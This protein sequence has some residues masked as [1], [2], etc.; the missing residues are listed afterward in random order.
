MTTKPLYLQ[1]GDMPTT[2]HAALSVAAPTV[3]VYTPDTPLNY[4]EILAAL[5]LAHGSSR[6][7]SDAVWIGPNAPIAAFTIKRWLRGAGIHTRGSASEIELGTRSMLFFRTPEAVDDLPITD[8]GM[9][10]VHNAHDVHRL[11]SGLSVERTLVVG[12]P[13]DRATHWFAKPAADTTIHRL[14]SVECAGFARNKDWLKKIL[15]AKQSLPADV[16]AR[17]HDAECAYA[18]VGEGVSFDL[19]GWSKK[20]LP[21]YFTLAPSAMHVA[22][23]ERSIEML[24][25]RGAREAWI[26]P[27]GAAK[28]TV[29]SLA[30]PLACICHGWER[31]VWLLSDTATQA[32]LNLRAVRDELENNE[33]LEADYP[34]ACGEGETWTDA[35]LITRNDVMIEALGA[36]KKLR[37][38]RFRQWRPSLIVCDDIENDDHSVSLT[39]REKTR[40]WFERAVLKAGT[41][42]TNVISTGTVL[43]RDCLVMNLAA[44]PGWNARVFRAIEKWPDKMELWAA[45]EGLL[46]NGQTTGKES[47]KAA[48]AFY[49]KNRAAMDAGVE[50]LWPEREDLYTLMVMRAVEGHTSFETEKQANPISPELCEWSENLFEDIWFETWPKNMVVR[51]V[52]LDPSKGKSDKRGDFSAIVKLGVDAD[53]NLWVEADLARRDTT[54]ICR[55]FV[56]ACWEFRPDVAVLEVNQAWELLQ[57]DIE[58]EARRVGVVLPLATIENTVAKSVRVR[59]LTPYIVGRR[60]RVRSTAGGR[61]LVD[62]CRDFPNGGHDDGPDALEM[63]V[64]AAVGVWNGRTANGSDLNGA[65][66]VDRNF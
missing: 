63:A 8:A 12:K 27:R 65:F 33:L 9:L 5:M 47:S 61:L 32:E 6:R 2:L 23:A 16:Y 1:L 39:R 18:A 42:E 43:H 13:P 38:R 35:R 49:Q 55:D 24:T 19:L 53:M 50:L 54:R 44:R 58:A 17:K 22:A 64:R 3:W 20:Y 40:R 46:L 36:G 41:S 26:G 10:I 52:A 30:Y 21:H 37:G 45:W 4:V 31:Y 60:V 62:Q 28:S 48:R 59:R 7:S 57:P 51:T 11:P 14:T 15:H 29:W 25:E 34:A 56:G 66:T